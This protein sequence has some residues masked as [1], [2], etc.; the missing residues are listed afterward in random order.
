MPCRVQQDGR[1]ARRR[2]PSMLPHVPA[3]PLP[4]SAIPI[5]VAQPISDALEGA[6]PAISGA[7]CRVTGP[8]IKVAAPGRPAEFRIEAYDGSGRPLGVGGDSFFVSVNGPSI[9][10]A[11]ITDH[12]DGTYTCKWTAPQSGVYKLLVSCFG[13][14]LDGSPFTVEAI[15]PLPFAP[16]CQLRGK[17]LLRAVARTTQ[18]FEI[19]YRDRLGNTA[20]AVDLGDA[21]EA[22]T[23]GALRADGLPRYML[24]A[25]PSAR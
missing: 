6:P 25:T 5:S 16:R 9:V 13:E 2:G 23:S 1:F 3:I 11:R 12:E 8:G 15:M 19:W 7:H 22:H 10:R 14:P 24:I 18:S 17:A 4:K 21:G 20:P